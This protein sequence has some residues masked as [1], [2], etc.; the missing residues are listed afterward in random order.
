MNADKY[1]PI[2]CHNDAERTE[3]IK[4][5]NNVNIHTSRVGKSEE[6]L[7]AYFSS[8][9]QLLFIRKILTKYGLVD[10]EPYFLSP[11]QQR[12]IR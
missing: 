6:R 5:L 2:M 7:L 3:I 11:K 12:M 10:E 4:I 1:I 8:D 9:T